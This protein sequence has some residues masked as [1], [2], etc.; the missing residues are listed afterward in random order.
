MFISRDVGRGIPGQGCKRRPVSL[1]SILWSIDLVAVGAMLGFIL[2]NR[3]LVHQMAVY[4]EARM[5]QVSVI[6]DLMDD[7]LPYLAGSM[8]AVSLLSLA[9]LVV[10]LLSRPMSPMMRTVAWAAL[11]TLVVL[12]G[13][14]VFAGRR[15]QATTVPMLTPTATPTAP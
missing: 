4:G 10:V 7:I 1:L 3:V 13:I 15:G 5:V 11:C 12:S 2:M 8:L 6:L 14:W 9:V